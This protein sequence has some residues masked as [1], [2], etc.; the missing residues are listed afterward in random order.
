[1]NCDSHTYSWAFLV[2][3]VYTNRLATR[4]CT[5]LVRV[6]EPQLPQPLPLPLPLLLAAHKH[7][8]HQSS[9]LPSLLRSNPRTHQCTR[10]ACPCKQASKPRTSTNDMAPLLANAQQPGVELNTY[11]RRTFSRSARFPLSAGK[12]IRIG[13]CVGC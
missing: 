1:M 4:L 7:S 2:Q 12:Q 13:E 9:H 8:I 10:G 11:P 3:S 6:Q 5:P